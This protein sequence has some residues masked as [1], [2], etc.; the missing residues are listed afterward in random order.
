MT[1]TANSR[2]K[3]KFV[4]PE[5]VAELEEVIKRYPKSSKEAHI[6]S[7]ALR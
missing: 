7:S 4:R 5:I 2:K 1:T 3:E 6:Y